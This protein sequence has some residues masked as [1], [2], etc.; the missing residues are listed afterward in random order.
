[1]INVQKTSCKH[2]VNKRWGSSSVCA[3]SV[4]SL[5]TVEF[6]LKQGAAETLNWT[7]SQNVKDRKP[8]VKVS[9]R[10]FIK[11]GKFLGWKEKQNDEPKTMENPGWRETKLKWLQWQETGSLREAQERENM[12]FQHNDSH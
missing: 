8:H 4:M 9:S 6:S 1:M 12:W 2:D 7:Q 11:K 3:E 10:E 5:S